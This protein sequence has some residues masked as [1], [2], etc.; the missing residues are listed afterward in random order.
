MP[1]KNP[2]DK[3]KYDA[4]YRASNRERLNAAR[5][6]RYAANRLE[7]QERMAEY[8]IL[9]R[10]RLNEARRERYATRKHDETK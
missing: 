4:Q 5:R 8:R 10:E 9:H 2:A 7:E 1:F 3:A 6:E